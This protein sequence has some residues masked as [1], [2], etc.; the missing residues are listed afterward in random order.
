MKC[1]YEVTLEQ[2]TQTRY[3]YNEAGQVTLA[4]TKLIEK[5]PFVD[6]QTTNC[7]AFVNGACGM[8][9]IAGDS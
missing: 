3:E 8:S 5:H 2:V 1:P 6:C 4:E 7:A 9:D